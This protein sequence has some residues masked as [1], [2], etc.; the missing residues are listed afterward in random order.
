[1]VCDQSRWIVSRVRNLCRPGVLQAISRRQDGSDCRLLVFR[2]LSWEGTPSISWSKDHKKL[3]LVR[4]SPSNATRFQVCSPEELD[5]SQS[6]P[7]S[8]PTR[9]SQLFCNTHSPSANRFGT[10]FW[11]IHECS[12]QSNQ[13]RAFLKMHP[14]HANWSGGI[15][16]SVPWDGDTT[17]K[18]LGSFLFVFLSRQPGH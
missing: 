10:L 7:P 2:V 8:I 11:A 9:V 5:N 15:S 4:A 1:M 17:C 16:R 3:N 6:L 18:A 14:W 12:L 13:K